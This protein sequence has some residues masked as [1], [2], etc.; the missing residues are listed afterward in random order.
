MDKLK[1]SLAIPVRSLADLSRV[2][3]LYFLMLK[4]CVLGIF[5]LQRIF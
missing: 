2:S 3:E 4:C 1:L 5:D